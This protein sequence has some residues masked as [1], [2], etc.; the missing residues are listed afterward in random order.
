MM[1]DHTP[2]PAVIARAESLGEAGKQWLRS[3][4]QIIKQLEDDWNI[5]VGTA[6]TGGT[7]AFVAP[8]DGKNGEQYAVKIDIPDMSEDEY[9]NEIRLLRIADGQGYIRIHKVNSGLRAALQER[10]GERLKD[11][12]YAIEKQIEILC[13]ALVQT[14]KTPVEK[15]NLPDGAECIAW[16]RGFI[17]ETWQALNQPCSEA[18]IRRAMEYLDEREACLKPDEYVLVHGDVHNN[19]ALE[20]LTNPGTFKLIDP[21]GIFYEPGYDLGVLMREWPEE[22]EQNPTENARAR[23]AL[24]HKLTGVDENSIRQWGFLQIVS[25]SFVLIQIGQEALARR[26]LGIAEKWA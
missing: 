17:A 24:L 11:K 12:N 23:C 16:F 3:I 8:A 26:M 20:S 10:L 4:P 15:P 5:T 13:S 2:S 19:N 9:M 25:T 1:P 14:W 6:M 21:D 7:H 18:V 22:Y